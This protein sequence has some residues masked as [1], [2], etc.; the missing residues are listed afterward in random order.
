MKLHHDEHMVK[1]TMV[2]ISDATETGT[3]YKKDELMAIRNMCDKYGLLLFIDGARLGVALTIEDTDVDAKLIGEVSDVFYV[4]GT[5][6]GALYGEA[7][8]IKKNEKSSDFRYYIKN[9]GSMLAK[10]FIL[11]IEFETLFTNNLYFNLAKNSNKKAKLIREGLNN[12]GLPLIGSS[13]SN[14]IFVE[15]PKKL[16]KTL[17]DKFG[18]ELW[19]D[20]DRTQVIRIVTSFNTKKKDA[21]ELIEFIKKA[22]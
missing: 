2:Y 21:E 3:T 10:G 22:L 17:M 16:A 1:L 20:R 9:S 15:V 18:V 13:K 19:E 5:K 7:L 6:N 14:Q 11:G 4:G 12:L 8:I